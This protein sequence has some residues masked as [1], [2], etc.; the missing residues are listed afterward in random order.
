MRTAT[1]GQWSFFSL[2]TRAR[3]VSLRSARTTLFL[4]TFLRSWILEFLERR[5]SPR[6]GG[7]EERKRKTTSRIVPRRRGPFPPKEWGGGGTIQEG[8]SSP[9]PFLQRYSLFSLSRSSLRI[10]RTHCR[11]GRPESPLKRAI[12][13]NS[14]RM[15]TKERGRKEGREE[16]RKETC[17]E[18]RL[19]RESTPPRLPHPSPPPEEID[20]SGGRRK[21]RGA[22]GGRRSR[23]G[24]EYYRV[25]FSTRA[26]KRN[27]LDAIP[28]QSLSGVD[29]SLSRHREEGTSHRGSN[30]SD[31]RASPSCRGSKKNK[32]K[33]QK[34]KTI[35]K[36][37]NYT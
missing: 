10:R 30:G 3:K 19:S 16:G 9:R 37:L 20:K 31:P 11:A 12:I 26:G 18:T 17:E 8:Q 34:L 6:H 15:K 1:S 28:G 25:F 7:G 4:L 35:T 2:S 36:M 5:R 32:I 29:T 23:A 24:R 14:E 27:G 13:N 33:K 21:E 22:G